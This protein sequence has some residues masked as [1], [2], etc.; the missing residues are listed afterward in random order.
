[1]L[2]SV[3]EPVV[4]SAVGAL[5]IDRTEQGVTFHRV[6]P[7]PNY[8]LDPILEFVGSVTSGVTF[9]LETDASVLEFDWFGRQVHTKFD[10][11]APAATV[12]VE[13]DDVLAATMRI[14]G[15]TLFLVNLATMETRTIEGDAAPMR[16]V[17]PGDGAL[18]RVR[19]WLSH[20]AGAG[21]SDV[22]AP[23]GSVVR[24]AVDTRPRWTHYG[25]SIS[26]C[27]EADSPS[28]IWPA[29]VARRAGLRL[30]NLGLA[31]QCQ[32]DQVVA[33]AIARQPAD[34]I[35]LKLGINIVNADSMRERVFIP[36]VHAFIDTVR[37]SQPHTP[38]V[39]VSPIHCPIAEDQPGPTR[40]NAD[41]KFVAVPRPD[42]LREGALTL[43]RIRTVLEL[44]VA[45]RQQAGDRNLHFLHG[46]ALFG[47]ADVHLM[48]DDLHPDDEGYAVLA[49]RFYALASERGLLPE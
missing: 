16:V 48:P 7:S 11:S 23:E 6:P 9:D 31:G 37:A 29:I 4:D 22:R 41:G 45:V 20:R 40:P 17:L 49:E 19:I 43:Q 30:T 5:R 33:H 26:Q 28:R 25:S 34:L 39:V 21:L 44:M 2:V 14:E 36:A 13:V 47:E 15:L 24:P 18:H 27:G 8:P 46:T 32:L 12:D 3:L 10:T 35:T 42:D 1:M 38:I